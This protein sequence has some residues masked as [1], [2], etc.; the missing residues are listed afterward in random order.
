[1]T[2]GSVTPVIVMPAAVAL[3]FV[4]VRPDVPLFDMVT[5][6]EAVLP[7]GTEPKLMEAGA[8][9]IVAALDVAG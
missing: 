4:I 5:D 7:S 6:C 9:E 2:R 8:T 3:A 1:M